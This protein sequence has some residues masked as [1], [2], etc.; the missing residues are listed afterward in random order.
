MTNLEIKIKIKRR[1]EKE[2]CLLFK[3]LFEIIVFD[4]EKWERN[5]VLESLKVK[6]VYKKKSI[7]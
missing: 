4:C 3:M 7:N 2:F 5:F 1:N 6:K